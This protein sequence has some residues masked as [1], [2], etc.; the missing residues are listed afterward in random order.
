MPNVQDSLLLRAARRE[1]AERTPVWFMRQAGRVLPEYRAVREKYTL[2]E[3]GEQPELCAEV[4]LQPVR[5]F[6]VDGAVLFADIMTPLAG[7]GVDLELVDGVGPVIARPIR[8]QQDLDALRPIEPDADVPYVLET[9]RILNRELGGRV[10]VI[11]FAG[12]PFTL[13][14]YLVEG[15]PSRDFVMVKSMMYAEPQLWHALMARL[16]DIII[17]YLRAQIE[18]GAGLV[19]LFDSW[20]GALSPLDYAEFVQPY[21]QRIFA[22]LAST[23][24]PLIHFGTNTATLLDRMKHDGAT[25]IGVDWRIPLDEAWARIGVESL[26]IQG[27]L[28]PIALFGTP[29]SLRARIGDVLARADG[30]PGHIF[31]L[32]HGLHPQTPLDNVQRAVDYVRDLSSVSEVAVW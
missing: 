24:A 18:A 5:R 31:N 29:T 3:I 9:I 23:G 13:A 27:N 10:P 2:F 32:G 20:V 22:A 21:A 17:P 7:V 28:D 1:L 4:T 11:G 30:R 14:A 25:I 12:A 16:T 26:G 6:D 15:K 8:S 19:Q